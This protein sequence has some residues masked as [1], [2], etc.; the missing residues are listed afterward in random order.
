MSKA[1]DHSDSPSSSQPKI[2][3]CRNIGTQSRELVKIQHSKY[4]A[5]KTSNTV[6]ITGQRTEL[7]GGVFQKLG[8][9]DMY[10][11]IFN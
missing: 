6:C 5:A 4:Y 9:I 2:M 1:R 11:E 8:L 7:K 3:L 10:E